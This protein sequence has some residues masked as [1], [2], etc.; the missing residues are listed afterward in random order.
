MTDLLLIKE[1][2]YEVGLLFN[3]SPDE[4]KIN[5]YS[6]ALQN[7]T[8]KQ[9]TFA[10]NQ[11]ILSGTAFFPS[12]A[13]VLKHLKP[14]E[15]SINDRANLLVGEAI[16]A[17][18]KYSIYDHGKNVLNEVSDEVRLIILSF[19][20]VRAIGDFPADQNGTLRAQLRDIAKG[21]LSQQSANKK[22]DQLQRI[23]LGN[24][25]QMPEM[26]TMDYSG[27]LPKSEA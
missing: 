23:G 15:P 25:L 5:A 2:V 12:L 14:E 20:G 27:F 24:V 26:R 4:A 8:P 7:Y 16:E 6:R 22:S 10:F 18:T 3:Q 21:V 19:G 1:A 13:E 9:I 11:V 17:A